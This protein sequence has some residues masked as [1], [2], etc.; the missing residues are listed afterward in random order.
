MEM[1]LEMGPL[2]ENQQTDIKRVSEGQ[3]KK[4]G[5]FAFVL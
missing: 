3:E 4:I 5:S 2:C 1:G